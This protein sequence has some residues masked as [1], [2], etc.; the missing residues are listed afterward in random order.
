MLS[1][2][3]LSKFPKASGVYWFTDVNGDVV[4][5]GSSKNLYNRMQLHR[6]YIKAGSSHGRQK[7]LYE[8][9]QK[10]QFKIEFKL[11]KEY[12]QKEQSLIEKYNPR[13]NQNTAYTGIDRKAYIKA[14]RESH[15]ED[16]KQYNNQK[17]IYNGEILTLCSLSTRFRRQGIPHPT[18]EAKKYLIIE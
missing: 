5:V 6:S 8:F 9:L 7:D 17:C 14:Y 16:I 2:I 11:T 4:Y 13:F 12:L 15:K 3:D 18:I 10:N 1:N